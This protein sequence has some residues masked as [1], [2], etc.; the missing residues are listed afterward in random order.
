[1][2]L[3]EKIQLDLKE[4]MKNKK[5]TKLNVLRMLKSDIKYVEIEKKIE[6][7]DEDIFEIINKSIKK[8]NDTIT[9]L[10]KSNRDDLLQD[11]INELDILK[12]YQPKQL[13]DEELLQIVK[14]IAN[15]VNA[16]DIKDMGKVMGKLMPVVK[17][18]CDGGRVSKAV[19]DYIT[20]K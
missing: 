16:V 19:K 12:E 4:A 10:K 15:E 9:Q 3:K 7:N 20:S 1:M 13:S 8:R 6:L 5:A 2:S 11:E 14:D 18:K 17:G